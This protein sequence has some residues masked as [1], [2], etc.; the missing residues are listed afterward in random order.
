MQ[1]SFH[2]FVHCN[3]QINLPEAEINGTE[4]NASS[5]CLF[6]KAGMAVVDALPSL[7]VSAKKNIKQQ[8]IK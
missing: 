2:A 7:I 3:K 6:C 1:T 5:E 8:K 4:P